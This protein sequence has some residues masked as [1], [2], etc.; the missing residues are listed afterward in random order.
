MPRTDLEKALV[1]PR[2]FFRFW[3]DALKEAF[4]WGW[5]ASGFMSLLI[6]DLIIVMGKF[7]WL[8]HLSLVKWVSD[9]PN[10]ARLYCVAAVIILYLVYAPY[11]K[12]KETQIHAFEQIKKAFDRLEVVVKER[13]EL[14]KKLDE[15]PLTGISLRNECDK[16]IQRAEEISERLKNEGMAAIPEAKE[17]LE[18]FPKFTALRLPVAAHDKCNESNRA[19]ETFQREK[20]KVDPSWEPVMYQHFVIYR[21]A[22]LKMFRDTIK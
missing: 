14:H 21:A 5:G 15:R 8:A 11:R 20:T 2:L 1:S 12:Y 4:K 13:D 6:P 17:W 7:D 18:E 3:F 16:W 9:N 10:L 19:G 22:M